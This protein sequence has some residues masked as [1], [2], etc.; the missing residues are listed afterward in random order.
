FTANP[1]TTVIPNSDWTYLN[2]NTNAGTQYVRI[3]PTQLA[4]YPVGFQ[5]MFAV[6]SKSNWALMADPTWNTFSANQAIGSN[7][8]RIRL[9][10]NHRFEVVTTDSPP[11][12]TLTAPA[13]T[14][15]ATSP[16]T[17][18][19][20]W[21]LVSQAAGYRVFQMNGGQASLVATLGSAATA[22]QVTGLLPA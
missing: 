12:V 1:T 22:Y 3:D 10:A 11:T 17:V 7:G 20:A 14:A 16:T 5:T 21:G 9:N 18:N 4:T 2:D 13:L 6:G 19:L 15:S 8:L